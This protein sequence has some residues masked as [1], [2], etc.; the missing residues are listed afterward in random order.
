MLKYIFIAHRKY[1]LRIYKILIRP[2][3]M[4]VLVLVVVVVVAVAR[5]VKVK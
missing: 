3:L 2:V 5:Q 1:K 4:V